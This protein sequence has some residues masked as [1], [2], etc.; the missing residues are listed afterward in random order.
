MQ[1][2]SPTIGVGKPLEI[3]SSSETSE[4]PRPHALNIVETTWTEVAQPLFP[5]SRVVS[6]ALALLLYGIYRV[7]ACDKAWECAQKS[8][9]RHLYDITAMAALCEYL[10]ATMPE[11]LLARSQSRFSWEE[12]DLL[13]MARAAFSYPPALP[14]ARQL[15]RL[16]WPATALTT[17]VVA[18]FVWGGIGEA[19]AFKQSFS[20]GASFSIA[21]IVVFSLALIAAL[22]AIATALRAALIAGGRKELTTTILAGGGPVVYVGM[23]AVLAKTTRDVAKGACAARFHLHHWLIAFAFAASLRHFRG[24]GGRAVALA[25]CVALGVFVEGLSAFGPAGPLSSGLCKK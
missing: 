23:C 7:G 13:T 15:L 3:S 25:K 10:R 9:R 11:P 16:A 24:V 4:S 22:L 8:P 12:R 21:P 17:A 18:T 6:I 14:S 5:R 1:G 2:P 20:A 19:K